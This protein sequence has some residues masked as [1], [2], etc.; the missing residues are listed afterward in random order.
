[1]KLPPRARLNAGAPAIPAGVAVA[2][3]P[4]VA[5]A[6]FLLART[7]EVLTGA[8]LVGRC[9]LYRRLVQGWV[10]GKVVRVSQA[11]LLARGPHPRVGPRYGG[12]SLACGPVGA[13]L[14][15]LDWL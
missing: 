5:P 14:P 6:R 10:L 1:M 12:G 4:L 7:A 15:C 3:V 2:A 9:I 13:A 8:A 11:P